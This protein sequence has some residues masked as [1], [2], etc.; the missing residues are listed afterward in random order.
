MLRKETIKTVLENN[1]IHDDN[2]VNALYLLFQQKEFKDAIRKDV[3][4]HIDNERRR[5]SRFKGDFRT[6]SSI[7]DP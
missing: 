2:L 1:S 7:L 5:K 3:V 4:D 6:P